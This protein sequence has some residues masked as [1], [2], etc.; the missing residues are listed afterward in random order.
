MN[1]SSLKAVW[2]KK[3]YWRHDEAFMPSF[4]RSDGF[5]VATR[6]LGWWRCSFLTFQE[7]GEPLGALP[8]W[9]GADQRDYSRADSEFFQTCVPY[10]AQGLKTAQLIQTRTISET[11]DFLPSKL[12][13]TGLVLMDR[14]G[15]IVVMDDPAR[16]ALGQLAL[17]DGA[18]IAALDYRFRKALQYLHRVTLATFVEPGSIGR[19]PTVRMYSHWSGAVLK[20]RGAMATG[21]DGREYISILVERGDSTELRRRRAMT[22]WGVSQRESEVLSFVAQGKT[23]SEIGTILG[24]SAMTVKKHLQKIYLTLGVEN[25]T[26]A[27]ALASE[28]SLDLVPLSDKR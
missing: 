28:N 14:A 20:L 23:N 16:L 9:R 1:S 19:L 18:G 13:G 2:M 27:A 10:I 8:I 15:E 11:G 7:F 24:I 22:R 12:W 5:N 17:L 4:H 3:S 26:A 6:P 21:T 25:R